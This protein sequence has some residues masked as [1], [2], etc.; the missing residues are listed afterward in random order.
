[1]IYACQ[2]IFVNFV[3]EGISENVFIHT[4]NMTDFRLI[5]PMNNVFAEFT[6]YFSETST[7]A[8]LFSVQLPAS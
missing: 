4:G 5:F 2:N 8:Q 7:F 3:C 1:M 6:G